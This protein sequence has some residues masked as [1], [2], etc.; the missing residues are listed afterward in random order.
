MQQDKETSHVSRLTPYD[1]NDEINL[2][3]Y[4]RALVK[5]KGLIG[6]IVGAVFVLSIIVSL[7]LPKIYAATASI[8]PPQQEGSLSSSIISQLPGGLGGLAGGFLGG[9]SA[10]DLWVGILN[11]QT[12][13]D[14]I[15]NQFDLR[16][17]YEAQ[18]IEA[19]RGALESNVTIEKS[20]EGI[21]SITVE[22]K[23]PERAARMAN[24]FV[25][26]LDRINK[27]VVMTSGKRMRTFVE[28]RIKNAKV[29]LASAEE[30][31]KVFQE[32]NQA[33][34]LDKIYP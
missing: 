29:E 31:V 33:V 15:I 9:Q 2:L 28:R 21:T 23:D 8:L 30:A 7:L 1:N 5:H 17:L 32:K 22:D 11:S 19:A 26:E 27:G 3:D 13:T 18:T 16:K 24:A 25:E 6:G 10:A 12:V 34:K 14:A 20:K 4:W